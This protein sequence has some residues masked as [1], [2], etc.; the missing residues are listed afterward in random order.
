MFAVVQ[1]QK[2]LSR[3]KSVGQNYSQGLSGPLTDA[4]CRGYCLRDERGIDK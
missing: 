4:K 1:D 2:E 3:L